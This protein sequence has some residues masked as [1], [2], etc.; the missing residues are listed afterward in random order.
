MAHPPLS[1]LAPW[2]IAAAILGALAC[3]IALL[4]YINSRRWL[5]ATLGLSYGA[6]IAQFINVRYA[7]LYGDKYYLSRDMIGWFK[8]WWLFIFLATLGVILALHIV[9]FIAWRRSADKS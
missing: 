1:L 3:T 8:L 6:L 4:K 5:W 7:T 9:L 2:F